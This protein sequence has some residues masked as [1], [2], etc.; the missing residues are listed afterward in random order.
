MANAGSLGKI[1]GAGSAASSDAGGLRVSD[2]TP[3]GSG[4]TDSGSDIALELSD[5]QAAVVLSSGVGGLACAAVWDLGD[6][7]KS[8]LDFVVGF[9]NPEPS[10]VICAG[11]LR[12]SS[13][14]SDMTHLKTDSVWLQMNLNASEKLNCFHKKESDNLIGQFTNTDDLASPSKVFYQVCAGP[15]GFERRQ[16]VSFNTAEDQQKDN[17]SA[18]QLLDTG[19]W[20]AWIGYGSFNVIS[21]S[22]VT[23]IISLKGGFR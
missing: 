2:A 13:A 1:A 5:G 12:R 9:T 20:Y 14:P 16:H 18:T 23:P 19:R 10:V 11:F 8:G 21:G 7:L 6:E 22:S 17:A 4:M 15:L 3:I